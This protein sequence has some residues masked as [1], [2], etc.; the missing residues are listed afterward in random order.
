MPIEG[1]VKLSEILQQVRWQVGTSQIITFWNDHWPQDVLPF[2]SR[3][4]WIMMQK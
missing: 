1:L 3:V 2:N 4:I